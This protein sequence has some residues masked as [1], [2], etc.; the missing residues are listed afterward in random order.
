MKRIKEKSKKI[1]I[2]MATDH[3]GYKGNLAGVG[4]YLSYILPNLD[5]T[6]FNIILVILR[7]DASLKSHFEGTGIKIIHLLRKKF[8]PYTFIEFIDII[9]KESIHLLHLHQYACSNFGRLAGKVIGIPTVLHA[10]DLNYN[11]SWIQWIADRLLRS[12]TDYVIAVSESAKLSCARIRAIDP[13]KIV[14]IPNAVPT[15][16]FQHLYQEN[17]QALRRRWGLN[18]KCNIVGTVTRLHEEKGNEFLLKAARI[19]LKTLPN[20]YFVFVG[21]GPLKQQLEEN[22][23]RMRIQRKVIFTGYQEDVAGLM[24]IFDVNVI[25]SNTEGFSLTLL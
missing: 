16:R 2:L 24:S 3:G 8:D 5:K 23:R 15:Y 25:A 22:T 9:K 20:T 21:D 7:D 4:R 14:V 17:C 18:K 12:T 1:N 10:H 19:I 6:R 13:N 11:Y